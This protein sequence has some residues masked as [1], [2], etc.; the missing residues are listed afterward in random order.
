MH[1]LHTPGHTPESTSYLLDGEALLTG[2]TLF[3]NG[4][5]RPDLEASPEEARARAHVIYDS[6]Q[7]LLELPA[8]TLV[9]PGHTN[10]PVAFDRHPLRGTLAEIRESVA[11]LR[12]DETTFVE[13]L[14]ARIPPTP[15]N[16]RRILEL[17]EAGL[18]P[19]ED[20]TDLEAG[21]NRC[22]VS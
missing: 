1:V 20:P 10:A 16:H 15:P 18:L 12:E 14:L 13:A 2:D 6:L 11:L 21:A 3:L 4:V 5:G 9:L 22:A 7:R 19:E 8:A 17:N